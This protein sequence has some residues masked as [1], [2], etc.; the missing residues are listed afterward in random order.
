MALIIV[1]AVMTGFDRDLRA[2]IVGNYAHI[3]I[4][5]FSPIQAA[6]YPG[7]EAKL[8]NESHVI[9]ISPFVYGQLLIREGE[10]F[11][12]VDFK[13]IN[14]ETEKKVTD[15]SRYL[16]QGNIIDLKNNAVIIGK[17]LAGSMGLRLGEE[18]AIYSPRGKESRLKIC[19]IFASGMYEYDSRLIFVSTSTGQELLEL[20][21]AYSAI[22]VKLDNLYRAQEV[23][24][25]LQKTLGFD[26]QLR[27]WMDANSNFV[28]ALK[29]EKLTMFIIL[30]LII[31][32]ASFNMVST[33]VVMVVEKTKDIGI[34][35]ALGMTSADIR[36]I[37]TI[38]GMLIGLSGVFFGVAG[39]VGVCI[40][41]SKYQF[42]KLPQDIYYIDRLPVALAWWPDITLIIGA[43]L[44]ITLL[45]TLYPAAKAAQLKPVEALRYE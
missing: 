27:T 4:H 19:G 33:L 12:A 26:Y 14:P 6:A 1:I 38:E 28:A 25:K 8:K 3:T 9:G 15:I 2:K 35:K 41:L 29:L 7:I 40:L 36:R 30:T 43:S 31:L 34:L 37:F 22:A 17:E 18:I 5:G 16:I 23:K 32:V 24:N 39:G 13:G 44:L 42:I 21:G 20:G 10:R 45:A 11:F